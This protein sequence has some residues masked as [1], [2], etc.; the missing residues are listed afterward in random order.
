MTITLKPGS[1]VMFTG[2]SVTDSHRLEDPDGLGTGYPLRVA[3]EWGFRHPDRPVTWLNTGW[4][5]DKVMD[6]EARWQDD[7]LAAEPDVVS[8]MIGG[9]DAA[10]WSFDPENG[11]VITAAEY[12]AGYER[13]LTPLAEAGTQLILIES[14]MLPIRGTLEHGDLRIDEALRKQWR[15]DLDPKLE[16]VNELAREYGAE[17]LA[18][19]RMFTELCELADPEHWADDGVHP[20]PAGHAALAEAWLRLVV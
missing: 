10:W 14:F 18:A 11:R 3:G 1:T 4:R 8:I 15:A 19:D 6:L 17:L 2:D 12:R 5:G 16:V 9:N 7:V 20:T 13:L